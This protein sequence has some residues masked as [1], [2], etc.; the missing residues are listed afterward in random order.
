M[1]FERGLFLIEWLERVLEKTKTRAERKVPNQK[2][3]RTLCGRDDRLRRAKNGNGRAKSDQ[4]RSEALTLFRAILLR[5]MTTA[6]TRA[7]PNAYQNHIVALYPSHRLVRLWRKL[8]IV[9]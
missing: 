4:V 5:M 8:S 6:P 1:T 3:D 2:A 7:E 9:I